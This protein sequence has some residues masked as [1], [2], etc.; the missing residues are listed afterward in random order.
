MDDSNKFEVQVKRN[1]GHA[2]FVES[3]LEVLCQSGHV[4]RCNVVNTLSVSVQANSKK[5]QILDLR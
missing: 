4:I 1:L 5:R 2:E 3:A